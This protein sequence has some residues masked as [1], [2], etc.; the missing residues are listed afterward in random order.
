MVW[1]ITHYYSLQ[2]YKTPWNYVGGPFEY[3][4]SAM[5]SGPRRS[6]SG[7]KSFNS[8]KECLN[9]SEILLY[10]LGSE[11]IC[12]TYGYYLTEPV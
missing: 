7:G 6:R 3:V 11:G 2:S 4:S 12:P 5:D 1:Y 10:D 8:L 9:F